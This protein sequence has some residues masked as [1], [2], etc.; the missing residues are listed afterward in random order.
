MKV[1]FE[2]PDWL[3]KTFVIMSWCIFSFTCGV[4][5]GALVCYIYDLIIH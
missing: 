2:I 1:E 5:L 4:L 3:A